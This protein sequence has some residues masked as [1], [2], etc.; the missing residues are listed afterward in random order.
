[1]YKEHVREKM[2]MLNFIH[3]SKKNTCTSKEKDS[4]KTLFILS[5][6]EAY[7]TTYFGMYEWSFDSKS[8]KILFFLASTTVYACRLRPASDR[9]KD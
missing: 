1:M 7:Y 4:D 6:K 2:G 8:D 3:F 5:A 9:A